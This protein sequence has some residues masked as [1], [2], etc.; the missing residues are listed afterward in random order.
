[1]RDNDKNGI[2][3]YGGT[4]DTKN[5]GLKEI[6][7][8]AAWESGMDN[9]VRFDEDYG[10]SILEN[11]D[12]SGK[13]VGYSI[14]QESVDLNSYL[15]AEKKLLAKI[16][17]IL[18]KEEDSNKYDKEAEHVKE[19]IQNN[20]FDKENGFFFDV[21]IKTKKPLINRGMGPEG[22]IPL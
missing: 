21:D 16:A 5:D 18:N 7:M 6:L 11:K 10:V 19:F 12:G 14:S 22:I 17:K 4:I 3:E 15:F 20:M 8:A 2:A 13:A 9:A 1:H